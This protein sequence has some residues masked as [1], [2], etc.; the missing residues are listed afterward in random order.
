V[1][2]D[3]IFLN[4][5]STIPQHEAHN[6]DWA[7][8][9]LM[10]VFDREVNPDTI[11]DD[12]FKVRSTHY[13]V[14]GIQCV[15][16]LS[17]PIRP[18]CSLEVLNDL[19]KYKYADLG[20]FIIARLKGGLDG[21]DGK[22]GTFM[23][24]DYTW[25]VYTTP[26]LTPSIFPVQI[27]EG[28]DL[29][30]GRETIVRV[31]AGL[32]ADSELEWVDADV[33]LIYDGG[34]NG[35]FE[36]KKTRFY[37][38]EIGVGEAK[39]KGNSDI[40]YS[41]RAEVPI[42]GPYTTGSHT[43]EVDV[44]PSDQ[45]SPPGGIPREH[46]AITSVGINL[47]KSPYWQSVISIY[48]IAPDPYLYIWD[49]DYPYAWEPK[50]ELDDLREQLL[51]KRGRYF[52]EKFFPLLDLNFWAR[53]QVVEEIFPI[54]Q[55]PTTWLPRLIRVTDWHSM[56]LG[57]TWI[58]SVVMVPREWM[59]KVNGGKVIYHGPAN[60]ACIV[61]GDAPAFER[62]DLAVAYC[63]GHLSGLRDIT[64][65]GEFTLKGYDIEYD[66][67]VD[68]RVGEY[69]YS[70]PLM[71]YDYLSG[72]VWMDVEN[73]KQVIQVFTS[74]TANTS[75][76][77]LADGIITVGGEIVI[78]DGDE[79]GLL[80]ITEMPARGS[81]LPSPDGSGDYS[82]RL[83]DC[84]NQ[85]VATYGF[86]PDF[87]NLEDGLDYASF[88]F[89]LTALEEPCVIE[90]LHGTEVLSEVVASNNKPQV[91]VVKPSEGSYTGELDASWSGGDADTSDGLTYSVYYSQDGGTTWDALAL[92]TKGLNLTVDTADFAN[93]QACQIKVIAHDGFFS[94]ETLSDTFSVTNPPE[95]TWVWP[96]DGY[97]EA[98][99]MTE[100]SAVFRDNMKAN[101]I[102][103][104][105]F[106]LKDKWGNAIAGTIA[107]NDIAKQAV[108]RPDE[109]LHYGRT[110]TARLDG[111]ITDT[112]GQPLGSDIEWTFRVELGPFPVFLPV[113]MSQ[114]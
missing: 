72:G 68:N 62:P 71:G 20:L 39:I 97:M 89:N 102:G 106:D 87:S 38:G 36:H 61:A 13:Y 53:T 96:A 107:Y 79:T 30:R 1:E 112:L 26:K 50:M 110:Y 101:T 23:K 21:V 51:L 19:S 7:N 22:D 44:V 93:C 73:Y 82:L 103:T 94:D 100:I 65:R 47:L 25:T 46:S 42:V 99:R 32:S 49:L 17:D 57:E 56:G 109:A 81:G 5:T 52:V 98:G 24:T 31:H 77:G 90:L 59:E 4:V 67:Y 80:D 6:V 16:D 69:D 84:Q 3:F 92:G 64:K 35:L 34:N 37:R 76:M 41:R 88:L 40:F 91:S 86:S 33:T 45:I 60:H 28:V 63:L 14:D 2:I 54:V 105:T 108:F 27:S 78:Q 10:P 83:T 55:S 66:R 12:T 75:E 85:E 70:V 8:G 48:P 114:Q 15:Y 11:R 9:S 18:K 29:L 104:S 58:N 95:V 74:P 43:I 111:S 113:V